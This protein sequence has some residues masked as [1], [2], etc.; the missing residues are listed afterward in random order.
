MIRPTTERSSRTQLRQSVEIAI[1]LEDIAY[2]FHEAIET[3][4]RLKA[5]RYTRTIQ[6]ATFQSL[7]PVDPE[8]CCKSR[9][10]LS[11]TAS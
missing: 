3:Y 2:R 1:N 9:I 6:G 4:E 11:M 10:H 5:I 8:I 7:L